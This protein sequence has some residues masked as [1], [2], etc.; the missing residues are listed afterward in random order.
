MRISQCYSEIKGTRDSDIYEFR[1]KQFKY[2]I[3]MFTKDW[4]IH[5]KYYLKGNEVDVND[6][7]ND[8]FAAMFQSDTWI[9]K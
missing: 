4:V 9:Q 7:P 2:T 5:K 8:I 6:I 1:N 3:Q